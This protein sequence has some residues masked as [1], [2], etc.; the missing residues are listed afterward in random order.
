MAV[1]FLYMSLSGT[2]YS[3]GLISD[4]LKSRM[5]YS[6]S[7]IDAIGLLGTIGAGSTVIA[8]VFNNHYG[9]QKSIW[10]G[11]FFIILGWC[12][13]TLFTTKIIDLSNLSYSYII[14]AISY[15]IYGH[16]LVWLSGIAPAT[17]AQNFPKRDHGKYLGLAKGYLGLGSAFIATFKADLAD[18]NVNTFMFSVLIYYPIA[19]ILLSRFL[20]QIPD[21][22]YVNEYRKNENHSHNLFWYLSAVILAIYLIVMVIIEDTIFKTYNQ[23][24]GIVFFIIAQLL[25]YSPLLIAM[26]NHGPFWLYFDTV[27]NDIQHPIDGKSCRILLG[28]NDSAISLVSDQNNPNPQ[29]IAVADIGMPEIFKIFDFWLM[30]IPFIIV[31]GS[32]LTFIANVSQIVESAMSDSNHDKTNESIVTSLVTIISIGNFTGRVIV[33]VIKDKYQYRFHTVFW[34][35]FAAVGMCLSCLYM[36]GIGYVFDGNSDNTVIALFF[37]SFIIGFS[38]GWMYSI[39]LIGVSDLYGTKYLSGN[40]GIFDMCGAIGQVIFSNGVFAPI[41]EYQGRNKEDDGTKCYGNECFQYAFGICSICCVIAIIM[42]YV[43]WRRKQP[44]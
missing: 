21:K 4:A 5:N 43:L 36:F 26:Y 3:F 14:I 38:F 12:L 40:F 42:F 17:I 37:G 6:Q 20:V 22:E 9:P 16:G 34:N 27:G 2:S 7:Q 18:G 41:Y 11:I 13:L 24:I 1:A 23:Y 25:F 39:I 8:G 44:R 15:F 10:F 33:G 35:I 19:C 29:K 30:W 32:G 28:Q 31:T